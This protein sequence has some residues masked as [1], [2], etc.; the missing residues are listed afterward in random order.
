MY[1]LKNI[2]YI[3]WSSYVHVCSHLPLPTY[4]VSFVAGFDSVLMSDL[5]GVRDTREQTQL[6][7]IKQKYY[8]HLH[9]NSSVLDTLYLSHVQYLYFRVNSISLSLAI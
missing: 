1:I 9:N 7:H 8:L 4:C 2:P 5:C 6:D 3:L